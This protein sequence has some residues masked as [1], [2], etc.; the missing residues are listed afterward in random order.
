[1]L[2]SLTAKKLN[3]LEQQIDKN[4]VEVSS[5]VK[6]AL[7][8]SISG[9]NDH[10]NAA[11]VEVLKAKELAGV[12]ENYWKKVESAR[13]FF[14]KEIESLFGVNL[15][16]KKLDLSKEEVDLFLINAYSHVMS[17]QKELQKIQTEGE[18]RLRRALDAVRGSDQSESVK[19]QLE[20]ELEKERRSLNIQNQAKIFRIKAETEKNLREQLKKQ[21]EAHT[22]HLNDALSNKES[23]LKRLFARELDEKI[24]NERASYNTQLAAMLGKLKGM[25]SALKE[26]ADAEKSAYQAQSLWAA[27]QT[28]WSSVRE[29]Q[30]GKSW[31]DELRPLKNE[32]KAVGSA[33]EGDE[34]V[35]VVLNT[36]PEVARDRGVFPEEALR[37]RF[38]NVAKVARRLALVPAE[39]ASLPVYLLSFIQAVLIAKP[40]ELISQ[41]ELDDKEFDF[42]KL[43]TYDILNRARYWMDR[44]NLVQTL[45]YMNL[46]KGAPRRVASEWVNEARLLLETQ[47]AVNVLLS[48]ASGNGQ[49]YL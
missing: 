5:E 49:R 46:L 1:M 8:Q 21:I 34:L 43:D 11:K 31:R 19:A 40:S 2:L 26:R 47:Q 28:L 17:Y 32:I 18:L 45:K 22:D 10:L 15:N 33:A 42:S 39:G 25:D 3:E 29:G 9:F 7:K 23:E 24:A 37:E 4:V 48:H 44:G 20:Y 6:S 13:S 12:S 27:C 14:V 35:A 36:L 41:D 38:V 30:P 16:D